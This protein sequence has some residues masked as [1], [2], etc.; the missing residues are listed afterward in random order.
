MVIACVAVVSSDNSPL[1]LQHFKESVDALKFHYL[2]HTSLDVVNEEGTL[3][4]I[5]QDT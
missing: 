3:G 4:N 1:Y 2:I 5:L